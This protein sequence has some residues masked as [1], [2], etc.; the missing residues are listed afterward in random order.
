MFDLWLVVAPLGFWYWTVTIGWFCL[1]IG[2]LEFWEDHGGK[3]S[4]AAFILYFVALAYF[5]DVNPLVWVIQNPGTFLMYGSLYLVVGVVWGI[6]KWYKFVDQKRDAYEGHVQNFMRMKGLT[7]RESLKNEDVLPDW[8]RYVESRYRGSEIIP[9]ALRNKG[10][11]MTWM[12]YWPFSVFWAVT[13]DLVEWSY[14]K[15]YKLVSKFAGRIV[16][17]KFQGVAEEV[18]FNK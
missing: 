16:E 4:S 14:T 9:T 15:L 5:W 17:R 11:I 13:G 6:F 3:S 8:Q 2:L 7:K 18:N 12:A 10:N 1:M